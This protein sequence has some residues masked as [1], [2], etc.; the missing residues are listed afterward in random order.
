DE[1]LGL[2]VGGDLADGLLPGEVHGVDVALGV[3]GRP[4]DSLGET[5]LGRQRRGHEQ[6]LRTARR[7]GRRRVVQVAERSQELLH[8]PGS[9]LPPGGAV[10]E[11]MTDALGQEQFGAVAGLLRAREVLPAL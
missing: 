11:A 5:L 8:A 7:G 3:A 4:L 2:A 10:E 9:A 6:L 1:D